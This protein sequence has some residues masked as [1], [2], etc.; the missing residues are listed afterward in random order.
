MKKEIKLF[1][2]NGLKRP[3]SVPVP[4]FKKKVKYDNFNIP[5]ASEDAEN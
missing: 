1:K 4:V 3:S 5:E 2:K